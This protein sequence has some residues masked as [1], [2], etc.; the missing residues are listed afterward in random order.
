MIGWKV[1]IIQPGLPYY[2]SGNRASASLT[3]RFLA[4]VK[5]VQ[6]LAWCR[7]AQ[8]ADNLLFAIHSWFLPYF[9]HS[10]VT[11]FLEQEQ[12]SLGTVSM[13][14]SLISATCHAAS[15]QA[16][17]RPVTRYVSTWYSLLFLRHYCL[18]D[19]LNDEKLEFGSTT[20]TVRC[21]SDSRQDSIQADAAAPSTFDAAL[22]TPPRLLHLSS[23]F[24][25][26][27]D[28]LASQ[29]LSTNGKIVPVVLV[30][31]K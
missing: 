17:S 4:C 8:S 29:W 7:L 27:S 16:Q 28:A 26:T 20:L 15:L 3:L 1:I 2:K 30:G 5:A 24:T 6:S 21:L 13:D 19:L 11:G 10:A 23:L 12:D 22:R 31:D 9:I 25:E 14:E 18:L